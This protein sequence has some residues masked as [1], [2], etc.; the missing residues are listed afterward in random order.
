M[1]PLS[2]RSLVSTPADV[3]VDALGG[4]GIRTEE[5][6]EIESNSCSPLPAFV[7]KRL[8]AHTR[9]GA[10]ETNSENFARRVHMRHA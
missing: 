2:F 8:V 1:Y 3:L 10:C 6:D 4:A 7:D 5:F 9:F